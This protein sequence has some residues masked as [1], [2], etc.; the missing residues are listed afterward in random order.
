MNSKTKKAGLIFWLI[1]TIVPVIGLVIGLMSPEGFLETQNIWRDRVVSF[2]VLAPLGLVLIQV[3]QVVIAPINHY[4]I[5]VLGGFLFGPYFGGLLNYIGRTIGHVIAFFI[6]RF[7]GRR[8]AERFVSIET[9]NKYDRYVSDKSV[10]LFLAYFL[11]VFPDDEISYIAGL[12]KM[13]TKK[14]IAANLF[15]QV[16]GSLGLAYIGA[17]ISTRDTL[18]WVLFTSSFIAFVLF[19]WL[20]RRKVLA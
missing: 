18:F 2:G 12:S 11:P 20:S 3:L 15:G 8:V 16:G 5:G 1:V 9:L 19:W 7:A 6:A 14:F 17:G 13:D 4:V 10:L